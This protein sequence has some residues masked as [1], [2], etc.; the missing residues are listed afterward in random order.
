[1]YTHLKYLLVVFCFCTAGFSGYAQPVVVKADMDST[2]IFIG[3]Q[4]K[5]YLEIAFD[6]SQDVQIPIF[7]DTLMHGVEVLKISKIDT[8]DIGNNR[9]QLKYNYLI[10]SFD[11]NVYLLPPFKA[12]HESDTAYSQ[13]LALKVST[14]PVDTEK[15][16]EYFDIKDVITPSIVWKDYFPIFLWILAG[17]VGI[18]LIAYLVYRIMNRKTLVPF[19]KSEPDLP[20]H[21]KAI[22]E[23][24]ELKTAK[25][26]QHGRNKEYHSS[27]TD[28]L[29]EYIDRRFNV[30]AMEM[31]SGEILDA[32][33]RISAS[34]IAYDNLKQILLLADFVKFA[35]YN[36]LPDENELSM[37]NAYVFVNNTKESEKPTVA[38]NNENNQEINNERL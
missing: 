24:N 37:M 35:K 23:L 22:R 25:L 4:T 38:E 21:V 30:G 6:K 7:S 10:T 29:R 32:L 1:M 28:I 31:T 13:E 14:I 20:P 26:W 9:I 34:D 16:E 33:K 18:A 15:A 27:I 36:P 5:I 19:K 12:I 3:E 8:T 11:A 2:N 17:I